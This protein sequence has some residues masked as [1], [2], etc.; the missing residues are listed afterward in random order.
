MRTPNSIL[1][2]TGSTELATESI[3]V[4][5]HVPYSGVLVLRV[6]EE[7]AIVGF[8]ND[9]VTS[10]SGEFLP[11]HARRRLQSKQVNFVYQLVTLT[12]RSPNR[13]R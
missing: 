4:E 9:I 10:G 5:C 13:I 11:M 12:V 7:S 3:V 6:P 1:T 8:V 2:Q